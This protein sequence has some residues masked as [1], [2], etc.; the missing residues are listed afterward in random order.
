[1]AVPVS[2]YNTTHN[3]IDARAFMAVSVSYYNTTHNNIEDYLPL[4]WYFSPLLV[5][6]LNEHSSSFT[7]TSE[8]YNI[9]I[10]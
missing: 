4:K 8:S 3:N 5:V 9:Y 1:M 10:K 2:Y 6:T 7:S